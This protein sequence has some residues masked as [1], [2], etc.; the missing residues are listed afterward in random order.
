MNM[1]RIIGM[2]TL[3]LMM[4][5]LTSIQSFAH[6]ETRKKETV[7]FELDQMCQNCVKKIQKN[8]PFEKGVTAF[9]TYP[10]K[11]KLEI[12]Y[13]TDKTDED[14][15]QEALGKLGLKVVSK[16]STKEESSIQMEKKE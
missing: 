9:K 5:S 3:V 6:Q 1:K 8:I 15:L 12:T 7:V 10:E 16:V 13:R 14:K 2:L 4:F 11:K